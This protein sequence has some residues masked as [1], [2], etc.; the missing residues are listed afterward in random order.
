MMA[1]LWSDVEDDLASARHHFSMAVA[2]FDREGFAARPPDDYYETM[3]VLHAMQSGYTA[4]EAGLKRVFL[5][6]GEDLPVGGDSHALMLKRAARPMPGVRPAILSQAL[7]RACNELRGFRHVAMHLYDR[8]EM[9]KAA[10][11]I[12]AARLF[13]DAIGPALSAFRTA[14][15]P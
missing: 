14:I 11:A 15:G 1:A 2:L 13:V 5:M 4:F 9:S 12:A 7:L 3:A 6:L 10:P 8:I